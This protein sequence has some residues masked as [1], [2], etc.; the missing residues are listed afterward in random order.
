ME[1][2]AQLV[3]ASDCESGGCGIVSR[4]SPQFLRRGNHEVDIHIS[5]FDL[6]ATVAVRLRAETHRDLN[7]F[8]AG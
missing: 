5:R 6:V 4:R 8:I 1:A 2:V 3:R 7:F